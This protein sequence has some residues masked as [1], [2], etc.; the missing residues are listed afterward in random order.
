LV[1]WWPEDTKIRHGMINARAATVLEARGFREAMRQR[2]CLV[3][4]DGLL[5]CKKLG[6][7]R[8]TFLIRHA[9][10]EPFPTAD[11]PVRCDPG[12]ALGRRADARVPAVWVY[13]AAAS[14]Y[15]ALQGAGGRGL[16]PLRR[17]PW[18]ACYDR[19]RPWPLSPSPATVDWNGNRHGPHAVSPSRPAIE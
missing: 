15:C 3:V 12:T 2:R 11:R 10:G 14:A 4:I 18:A 19:P 17:I 16:L 5:G 7:A 9:H 6:K 13:G 1:P 8:H